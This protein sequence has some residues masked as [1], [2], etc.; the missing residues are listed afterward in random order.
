[1]KNKTKGKCI[2]AAAMVLCVG[3]PFGATL[4]QFPV[5]INASD[6]AT[7]SGLFLVMAFLSCLPFIKQIKEYFKSPASWVVWTI[8]L[9]AFVAIRNIIDQMI[10]VCIV[11]LA[12]NILGM[13]M[14]K[15]GDSV[16]EKPDKVTEEANRNGTDQG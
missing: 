8:V 15:I 1:M 7:V 16:K 2:R 14:F 9:V 6:K 13:I 5:W 3:A 10:F 4:S 11:G 12:A